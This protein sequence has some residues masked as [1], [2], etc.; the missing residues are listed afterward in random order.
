MIK[1]LFDSLYLKFEVFSS[2]ISLFS[3]AYTKFHESSVKKEIKLANLSRDDK[4]IHIGCGAIPYTAAVLAKKTNAY[5]TGIDSKHQTIDI[6]NV[7]LKKHNLLDKITIEHGD[8]TTYDVS[9]F[10]TVIISYGIS[11]QDLVLRHVLSSIKKGAKI[12]L[13]SSTAEKNDY[14]DSVVKN[15]SVCNKKLLLTQNSI[16]IIKN[17]TQ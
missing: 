16:V 10:D 8:G 2:H 3:W 12:V 11:R 15:L 1:E 7:Y 13:R 4:I 14:I 9:K 5:I 17:Q 6:A